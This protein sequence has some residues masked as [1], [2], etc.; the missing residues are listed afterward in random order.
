MGARQRKSGARSALAVAAVGGVVAGFL[1]FAGA[2]A[3]QAAPAKL[4][5]QYDCVFPLIGSDPIEATIT[6]EIPTEI[7]VG[8]PSP[9]FAV[10]AATKVSARAAQGLGLVGGKTL[11]GKA[12]ATV[13]VYTPDGPLSGIGVENTVEK[14]NIPSPPADFTV[15]AKGNAPS[16]TFNT[17]GDARIEVNGI[18]LHDMIVRDANGKPIQ[19][20]TGKDTFDAPCTLKSTDKVLAS[21][22][23]VPKSPTNPTNPTD[24]TNPTNPTNPTDP[25]NPTNPTDPTAPS[26]STA[27]QNLSTQVKAAAGTLSMS[28]PGDSVALSTVNQG[29]GGVSSGSLQTVTVKDGRN[30][31]TGWSLTGK[32]T[33]FTGTAG[34]I[35]ADKLS[36]KPACVTAPGSKSN[37]VAGTAGPVGTVG[38]TLAGAPDAAATGGQ[39]SVDGALS[40]DIPATAAAGD[41]KAVLTLTLT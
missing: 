10:N 29:V 36:W 11:E 1:G 17:A 31:A 3:A 9:A 39:F 23:V 30:G 33:D 41:Y 37:C 26:G 19:L 6:A 32:V 12:T 40:L 38:A 18:G 21:F 35:G 8:T 28:Q 5:Q 7:E 2:G 24:P 13:T 14:T 27:Q 16:L 4:V 15:N 22:K 20:V 34:A 25:T